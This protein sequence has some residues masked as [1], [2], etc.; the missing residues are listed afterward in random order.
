MNSMDAVFDS[1]VQAFSTCNDVQ[2][3]TRYG[4]RLLTRN[5]TPFAVEHERELYLLLPERMP[6][7]G[8]VVRLSIACGR[9]FEQGSQTRWYVV[10]RESRSTV[11]QQALRSYVEAGRRELEMLHPRDVRRK[12]ATT[13]NYEEG[14]PELGVS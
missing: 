5:G 10:E 14:L 12:V 1:L 11:I 2:N 8:K 7:D 3:G 13:I 9:M 6:F 4:L